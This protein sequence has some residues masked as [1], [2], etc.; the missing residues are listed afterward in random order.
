MTSNN[1]WFSRAADEWRWGVR[2]LKDPSRKKKDRRV[3]P[4]KGSQAG[5]RTMVL[6]YRDR[7]AGGAIYR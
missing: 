6:A 3:Y 2:R 5:H 4:S 7:L 1:R